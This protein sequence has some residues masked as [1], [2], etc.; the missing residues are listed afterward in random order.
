MTESILKIVL[1]KEHTK[2]MVDAQKT[3]IIGTTPLSIE[4]SPPSA[5]ASAGVGVGVVEGS[6][7]VCVLS[8]MVMLL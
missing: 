5:S 8:A 1:S 4:V 2:R 3:P 7:S 6:F